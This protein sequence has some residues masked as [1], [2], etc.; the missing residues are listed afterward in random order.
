M[1]DLRKVTEKYHFHIHGVKRQGNVE[2]LNTDSG[3]YVLKK[4][5]RDDLK[6]IFRYLKGRQFLN[7]VDSISDEED[8]YDIYPYYEN[9]FLTEEE[10]IIELVHLM[11]FLHNKTTSFQKISL[12]EVKEFYETETEKLNYLEKYYEMLRLQSEEEYLLAPSKYLFLR[13]YSV[14]FQAIFYA[15]NFLEEWYQKVKNKSN[16]RVVLNHNNL[17]SSHVLQN[18]GTYLISWE[19]SKID[20]PVYDFYHF[21]QNN[22]KRMD[23]SKIFSIYNSRYELLEEEKYLL[24]YLCLFPKKLVWNEIEIENSKEVFEQMDYLKKTLSF[25]LEKNSI[26]SKSQ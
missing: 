7:F 8:E 10:R 16:R 22:Y 24:F 1:N 5:R 21:Y 2:I 17:D 18:D 9:S 3:R 25:I 15:R 11:S 4:K 26:N 13:S 12:D 23:V 14:L 20:S 19:K 6:D